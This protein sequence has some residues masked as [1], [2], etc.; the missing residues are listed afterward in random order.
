MNIQCPNCKITGQISDAKIPPEGLFMNCPKC[1]TGF[2]VRKTA[3]SNWQETMS[4]CPVCQ[5]STFSDERFDICPNCGLVIK[6][7]MQQQREKRGRG[8]K[9]LAERK[10]PPEERKVDQ[11]RERLRLEEEL[12]RFEEEQRARRTYTIQ[13][14]MNAAAE[15]VPAVAAEIPLPVKV[16]GWLSI[17]VA[18][19]LIILGGKG[20]DAYSAWTPPEDVYLEEPPS[21]LAVFFTYGL[22][23]GVQLCL[24][25]FALVF[26]GQYLKLRSWARDCLEKTFWAGLAVAFIYEI[27]MLVIFV[28]K[29]SS[30]AGFGYYAVGVMDMLLMLVLW[31]APVLVAI[32]FLRE[33]KGSDIF[34]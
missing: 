10:A 20:L 21:K 30:G 32:R 24:G 8:E 13:D 34:F 9:P 18:A 14:T 23:P 2:E 29:S 16:L 33:Q 15:E 11:A 3:A 19:L 12:R 17:T 27:T 26:A 22:L 6:D 1:K 5:Y 25:L 28:R 7:Y 4:D 31:S